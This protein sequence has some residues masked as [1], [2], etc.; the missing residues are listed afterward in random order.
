MPKPEIA[1]NPEFP[2]QFNDKE[3]RVFRKL[4][5]VPGL[6]LAHG[7]G[8]GKTRTSI[9]MANALGKPTSV[10]VPAA[11]Q[12]NY[13]KELN[14]WLGNVPDNF[15]I[16]SQ[17]SAA[18]SGLRNPTDS[19]LIVDEAHRARDPNSK[20]LD[21]LK[22]SQASKRLLLT[23]SPV[24]NHPSDLSP[25]VN[26]AANKQVL[27]EN[28]A[29]FNNKFIGQKEIQP[30]FLGR[31]RGIQ[32]G[33]EQYL[34]ESPDL[35]NA[36][37]K[38]VDYE[39]GRSEGFPSAQEQVVKVPLK[40]PQQDIYNT[41]M[42]KAPAWVRWKVR[43]GLPP[44][45]GELSTLQAF[46]TGARQVSNSTSDFVADRR[47]A[48]MPKIQLAA[49]YLRKNLAE[50]PRYKGVVYSNYLNSGLEP[51]KNLLTKHNIPY[52]EFSGEM[53]PGARNQMVKDYNANKLRTLLISSAGAE[54]LDLKGTRLLQ[55]LEPHWNREKEKQIVG[56]A[57]RYQS[58]A[59]LP[60]DEQNVLIQRYLSQPKGNWFDK[61][62]GRDTV[63]GTDEYISDM[64][65]QKEKLNQ[66]LLQQV[67]KYGG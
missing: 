38:Y 18:V 34:K 10:V 2:P 3:N 43:S 5:N 4:Q 47:K 42:G 53:S 56:R 7:L 61:L 26:M 54:G 28:R 6:V 52:G 40:E 12:D 27:P 9:Q 64:A 22:Q 48:V 16:E 8:T 41:I 17:Q 51:Y 46:L 15:H 45:K 67:A 33:Q 39:G 37:K 32:P 21:A 49:D 24:Y 60:P 30:S 44:G 35:R 65:D 59:G 23:A 14:R 11:L 31:L 25:L 62:L 58:H 13:K 36:I 19:T 63:R 20:L 57:I 66:Q 1:N 50:N 29:E 55:I